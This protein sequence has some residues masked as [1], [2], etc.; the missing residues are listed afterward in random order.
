MRW[1]EGLL[2]ALAIGLMSGLAMY[3]LSLWALGLPL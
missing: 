3:F 2:L 1:Y